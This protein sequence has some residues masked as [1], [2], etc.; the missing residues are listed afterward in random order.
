[1]TASDLFAIPGFTDPVSSLSH[2]I[3]AGVFAILAVPLVH[4]GLRTRDAAGRW[5]GRVLSL[6]IFAAS[7]VLLLTLSGVFHLLDRGG[8]AR[9]VLQRLDHAAI[10]VLI[11]GTCTPIHAIMFRGP[12][13]WGALAA[14]WTVAAVGVTLKSIYFVST[15][16]AL[17]LGLYLGM[18]WLGGL[19]IVALWRRR[20]LWFVMPLLLGGLA[21]TA[22][23]AIE[24]AEPGPMIGG[25]IRAHEIFHI[26]VLVGLGPHWR[27][28][29]S[30]AGLIVETPPG[31][32]RLRPEPRGSAS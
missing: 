6:A 8:T 13:R 28:V 10:F 27:F 14:I 4:K 23:A 22:G 1:M 25:V 21:Y 30:I 31:G 12:T 20:G 32:L 3:G 18:G 9:D 19:S 26:A 11:A 2:L 16:P 17:G 15:P 5:N 29:W 24:G 7:A